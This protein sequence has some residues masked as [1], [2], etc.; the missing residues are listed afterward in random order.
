MSRLKAELDTANAAIET[1]NAET[2]AAQAETET[3]K[4]ETAAV[5]AELDA[6]KTEL[7]TAKA[8]LEAAQTEI[9]GLNA[10]NE[11][12]QADIAALS[13]EITA[14]NELINE[15]TVMLENTDVALAAS[16]AE[17]NEYRVENVLEGAS[18]AAPGF[19]ETVNV[20]AD[21]LTAVYHLENGLAS[22][23]SIVCALEVG[24]E[25]LYESEALV[26]G[27]SLEGFMLNTALTSGEYEGVITI[28]TL[29]ADGNVSSRLT[30]NVAVV[31]E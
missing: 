21:G 26:P 2:A 3:A 8:E 4:A 14:A 20:A 18:H 29:G 24:G 22:G 13:A 1:A 6:I 17:L 5:Q 15:L 31:V 11:T 9:A 23:N 30:M 7:E 27:V 12:A 19:E 25:V 10:D 28:S 16:Q